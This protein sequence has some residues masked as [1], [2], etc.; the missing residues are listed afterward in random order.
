MIRVRQVETSIDDSDIASII[1]A[2]SKKIGIHPMKIKKLKI[3]KKSIDARKKPLLKFVYEVDIE[4]D[5]EMDFLSRR[6]SNDILLTP[7]ENYTFNIKGTTP[8]EKR[9]IIV[10]SG[11]AGLF[12]AYLLSSN[13]YKPII[14]ER[15]FD[16][17]TRVEDVEQFWKTGKLNNNSN[18]Q[19]GEG[20]AG[21]FSDGK[22]NTGVKDKFNRDKEVLNIFVAN[23]APDDILYLNM[24]HIGT[25]KLRTVVKN[26]RNKIIDMGGEFRYNTCLTNININN[27]KLE[28]ITVNDH[29]KIECDVL[30]LAIGHSARDTFK[31]LYDKKISMDPKPFAVGIRIQHKQKMID[32]NQYGCISDKCWA[33]SYKLTYKANNGRGVYS[34][35]MCPGGYVVNSSSEN[36]ML[37]I[38]G[39]S[40]Y[41]RESENAN[42]A[43]IVTVSP[44]DFGEKPLDGIDFQR[45]LEEVSYK[46]GDGCIPIQLYKDYKNNKISTK[47]DS[48]NPIFKGNYKFANINEIFPNY[49]NDALKEGIESFNRQ[50]KG[51]NCDDAIIAAVES[52][53]SSP[54]RI[55]R[56]EDGIS[57]INGIYPCGEGAGY[58]GGITSAAMDGM[59]A[60]EFIA[61]IYKNN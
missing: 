35:C 23:G 54:V 29:E 13:G 10:G 61:N 37:A 53:T 15:G 31:M 26:M 49:I 8:L 24:P 56:D 7:D 57:S 46:I 4:I 59:K 36:N 28:S 47:F 3:N 45:K 27:N 41:E 1:N 25:D 9:L 40:N 55:N 5:D 32:Y 44:K 50:I 20:G 11:P 18:V 48:I 21:T 43:I 39:M 22:L 42:S 30:V 2:C 52:R 51:F 34:F 33:A 17:D 14:I 16:V 12:C 19:F 58:A 6:S 60:A 38:N